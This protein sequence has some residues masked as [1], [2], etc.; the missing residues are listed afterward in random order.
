M[1]AFLRFRAVQWFFC[2]PDGAVQQFGDAKASCSCCVV[3]PRSCF[4]NNAFV[5]A[6]KAEPIELHKAF[7]MFLCKACTR[8]LSAHPP[9]PVQ[10]AFLTGCVR[11]R[12]PKLS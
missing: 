4:A 3:D 7:T 10:V 6:C 9:N 8:R 2:G 1:G 12:G 11:N 5:E